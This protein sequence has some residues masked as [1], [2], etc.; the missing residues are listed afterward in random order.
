MAKQSKKQKSGVLPVIWTITDEMW[1]LIE[2]V[3]LEDSPPRATG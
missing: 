1:K 2:P 3:L